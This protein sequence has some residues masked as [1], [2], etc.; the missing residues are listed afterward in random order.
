MYHFIWH[1]YC[2]WYIEFSKTLFNEISEDSKETKKVAIWVFIQILKMS[3]PIMPFI[4]E[5]LWGAINGEKKFLMNQSYEKLNV[6]NEFNKSQLYI[7]NLIQIIS[8]V[9]NIRSE[10]NISYKNLIDINFSNNKSDFIN[11]LKG[12]E[13]EL[14]RLLKLNNLSFDI[15]TKKTLGAAYIVVVDTTITI[16]L[17]N[18]VDTEKEINK[19][20]E[21]KDK[22]II[23]LSNIN[24]KLS[25]SS[26]LEK[27]PKDIIKQ[28]NK[29]A[30]EIKSSIEKIDQIID[31]IK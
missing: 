11:F 7:K 25:N 23:N 30:N 1:T 13:K 14:K 3:H 24:L 10:L 15:K 26:F 18:I 4:T 2:D 21:K 20:Q 16:P 27:A 28:F 31:T 6:I 22:E 8:A 17:K 29:Q 9:R 12:Y 19:L 5:Q